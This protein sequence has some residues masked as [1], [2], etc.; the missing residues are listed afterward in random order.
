MNTA[1]DFPLIEVMF[2]TG[3]Q[4]I[5]RDGCGPK[6]ADDDRAGV[7]GYE[8]CFQRCGITNQRKREHGDRGI[9]CAG[10]IKNISRLGWNVVGA[11]AFLEKHH[12]VF[13]ER[14]EKILHAPF[15]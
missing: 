8:C 7:I 5:A 3:D 13:A 15:L 6:F 1:R 12:A 9:P 11:F 14:N 2:E 4:F 10:D